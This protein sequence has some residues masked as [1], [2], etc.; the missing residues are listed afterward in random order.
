MAERVRQESVRAAMTIDLKKL[1]V[2]NAAV[3][4][5]DQHLTRF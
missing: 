4:Q 1:R 3:R 2:A 5:L